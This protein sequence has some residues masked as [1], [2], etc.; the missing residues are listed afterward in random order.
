MALE[1]VP[2]VCQQGFL[3]LSS[4]FPPRQLQREMIRYRVAQPQHPD[5]ST[6]VWYVDEPQRLIVARGEDAHC[7]VG[8]TSSSARNGRPRS[9][10]RTPRLVPTGWP[11][12]RC[13][14]GLGGTRGWGIVLAMHWAAQ[15]ALR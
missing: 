10:V 7:G 12:F 2:D 3:A 8:T 1:S 15:D 13:E 9:T 14:A 4:L 11:G 5:R 6:S